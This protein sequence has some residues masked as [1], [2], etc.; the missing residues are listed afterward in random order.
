MNLYNTSLTNYYIA[1]MAANFCYDVRK[2]PMISKLKCQINR[3]YGNMKTK[4]ILYYKSEALGMSGNIDIITI[5]ISRYSEKY[6]NNPHQRIMS[7]G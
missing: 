6:S 4:F 1:R 5:M 2:Y 3:L 7:P